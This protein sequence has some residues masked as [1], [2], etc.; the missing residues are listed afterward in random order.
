MIGKHAQ[1][2]TIPLPL[3]SKLSLYACSQQSICNPKS[4]CFALSLRTLPTMNLENLT[5]MASDI[6]RTVIEIIHK[7]NASHLGSSLSTIEILTS[8]YSIVD[9]K[10]IQSRTSSRD[11]VILSKGHA[12][13]ALYSTLYHFGLMNQNQISTYHQQGSF[14][15]GHV[16]HGVE[17]VEH[18]TGALGHGP[19]VAVGHAIAQRILGSKSSTYVICGDGEIQEGSIWEAMMYASTLGLGNLILLVDNNGISSI[20]NTREV[21]NYGDLSDAFLGFGLDVH[22]VDGHDLKKL[23]NILEE[24]KEKPG[25]KPHVIICNTVKGKGVSFAESQ[26]IWHY[27][28]LDEAAF[29]IAME[30]L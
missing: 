24:L 18:S 21:I 29:Q 23:V 30:N 1:H 19:S 9:L 22:E 15:Q 5:K 4:R 27:R 6:R 2:F 28:T 13:A 3:K 14:L 20:T 12:A 7:A 26:A 17:F 8:I 25:I 16:S 11:I 10:E